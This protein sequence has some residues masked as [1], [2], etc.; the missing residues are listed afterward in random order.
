MDW[1]SHKQEKDLSAIFEE[2]LLSAIA[3][4]FLPMNSA[5]ADILLLITGGAVTRTTTQTEASELQT[6]QSLSTLKSDSLEETNTPKESDFATDF[7]E[8]NLTLSAAPTYYPATLDN[9]IFKTH[10]PN[11]S[12]S[13]TV[14]IGGVQ[15]NSGGNAE[16]E[17]HNHKHFYPS[18]HSVDT[19]SITPDMTTDV[20]D[21]TDCSTGPKSAEVLAIAIG[22]VFVTIILGA[23]LYQF[24]VFMR[25]K[26]AHN[27]C[28]VYVI[29]N[30]FHKY[31][32]EA[33]GLEGDTKL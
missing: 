27:D 10:S 30:E 31:D 16:T 19:Q 14:L 24:A 9:D 33:N 25:K 32:V 23:L 5:A 17:I 26:R 29:E 12:W 20:M 3:I 18:L 6:Y 8:N 1:S 13:T 28:S 22:V 11:S 21:K 15:N 7:Q 2:G 4:W